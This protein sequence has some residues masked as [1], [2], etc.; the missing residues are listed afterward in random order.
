MKFSVLTVTDILFVT[1]VGFVMV[2]LKSEE[3]TLTTREAIGE[4]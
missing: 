1:N 3:L 2:T 4:V